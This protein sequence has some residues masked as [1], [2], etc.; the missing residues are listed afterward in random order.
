M[1]SRQAASARFGRCRP[2]RGTDGI[3]RVI[4]ARTRG[5][6]TAGN[7]G[8]PMRRCADYLYAV[9]SAECPRQ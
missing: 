3:R 4:S 2:A 7:N 9:T 8:I 6:T 5:R 1:S